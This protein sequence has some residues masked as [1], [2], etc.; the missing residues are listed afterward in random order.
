MT[1]LEIYIY[2]ATNYD[3]LN[4]RAVVGAIT[5]ETA[6]RLVRNMEERLGVQTWTVDRWRAAYDAW[7]RELGA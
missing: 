7:R 2:W 4:Q 6:D 5:D 3:A 1:D